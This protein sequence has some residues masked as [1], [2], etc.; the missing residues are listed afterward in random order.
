[1]K[2]HW[3]TAYGPGMA[4][5]NLR[6]VQASDLRGSFQ[7]LPLCEVHIF[8]FPPT[9]HVQFLIPRLG[10]PNTLQS[11]KYPLKSRL[12]PFFILIHFRT[13]TPSY[14][15]RSSI[16]SSTCESQINID[17]TRDA[18]SC[19]YAP[20][21]ETDASKV[22]E[23]LISTCSFPTIQYCREGKGPFK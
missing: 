12:F 4:W 6:H 23:N 1:M 13:Q 17:H 22:L 5:V 21:V 7:I 10:T 16:N 11:S 18:G 9:T 3:S 15:R 2:H 20:G 19:Q 14:Q 8:A